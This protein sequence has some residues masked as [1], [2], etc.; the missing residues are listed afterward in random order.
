ME[1]IAGKLY[2][3][4]DGEN[5]VFNNIKKATEVFNGPM[6][7]YAPDLQLGFNVGYGASDECATGAVTGEEVIVDNDSRWSGSHLMDPELVRGVIFSVQGRKYLKDP[8]LED[9]TATLYKMFAV[10]PPEDIDGEPLF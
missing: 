5:K 10:S 8:T 6:L 1:E 9:L 7:E 3:L 2:N 4:K